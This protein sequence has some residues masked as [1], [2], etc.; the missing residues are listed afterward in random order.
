MSNLI[1]ESSD[2]DKSVRNI[3]CVSHPVLDQDGNLDEFIGTV[4]DVTE[5]KR[6]PDEERQAAQQEREELNE[7]EADLAHIDRVSTLGRNGSITGT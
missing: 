1:T 4:I 2:S 6:A 3:H 5:R 7:L